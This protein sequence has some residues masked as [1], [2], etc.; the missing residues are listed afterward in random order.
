MGRV[1]L[2]TPGQGLPA[3]LESRAGWC[4]VDVQALGASQLHH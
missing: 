3:S 1:S 4:L 2:W